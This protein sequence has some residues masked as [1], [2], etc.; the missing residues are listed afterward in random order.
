MFESYTELGRR[1]IFFAREE[2][3]EFGSAEIN[4]EHLLLGFLRADKQLRRR[5]LASLAEEFLRAEIKACNSLGA[6][7]PR[8]QDMPLSAEARHVLDY[9]AEEAERLRAK[10]IGSEHLLLGLLREKRSLAADLLES[11][12]LTLDAAR[13]CVAELGED[14][15]KNG[16]AG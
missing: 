16:T 4:T 2:A 14:L 9:A 1:V 13:A 12:G 8:E 11:H 6:K 10:H 5:L 15:D 3:G 7:V